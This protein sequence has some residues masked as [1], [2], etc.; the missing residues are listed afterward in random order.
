MR[1]AAATSGDIW[2]RVERSLRAGTNRSSVTADCTHRV[3]HAMSRWNNTLS[4]MD[5]FWGKN[6]SSSSL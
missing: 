1:V 5:E 3:T 6:E 2:R 4:G